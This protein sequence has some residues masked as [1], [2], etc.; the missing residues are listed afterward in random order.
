MNRFFCLLVLSAVPAAYSQETRQISLEEVIR[1]AA[2]QSPETQLAQIEAEKA[3]HAVRQVRAANSP[4]GVPG[5]R[6]AGQ[7][8]DD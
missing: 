3:G 6:L 8:I 4:C 5:G 7:R 1:L 2:S